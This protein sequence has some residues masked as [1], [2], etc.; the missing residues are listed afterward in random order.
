MEDKWIKIYECPVPEQQSKIWLQ[1]ILEDNNI[2]FESR[3]ESYWV[4]IRYQ[5]TKK[6]L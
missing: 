1:E 5:S 3:V 6:S 4:G 2:S